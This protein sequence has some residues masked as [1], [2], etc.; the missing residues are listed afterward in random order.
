MLYVKTKMLILIALICCTGCAA[1]FRHISYSVKDVPKTPSDKFQGETL[2]VK[3][4]VD[5]RETPEYAEVDKKV[6]GGYLVMK[7]GKSVFTNL[8][9]KEGVVEAEATKSLLKHI[10]ASGL[11]QEVYAF[12]EDIQADFLLE[13]KISKFES[14]QEKSDVTTVASSGIFGCLGPIATMWVK[15]KFEGEA[16]FD[17]LK[18]IRTA[19]NLVVW[20]GTACGRVE[21]E[22]WADPEGNLVYEK[23][24]LSLKEAVTNLLKQLERL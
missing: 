17:D 23:A 21:G 19:D 5:V 9:Y 6:M 7:N 10:R 3:T 16:C 20:E 2:A 12:L 18:L 4:M 14:F 11:F 24:N 22:D 13:G 1:S 15:S 8:G